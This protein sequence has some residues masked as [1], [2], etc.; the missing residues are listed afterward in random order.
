MRSLF[1]VLGFLL[2]QSACAI[3]QGQPAPA[4]E[5]KPLAGTAP[6]HLADY[7]GRVVLLDF[8]ASWCGPCRQSLPLFEKMRGEFG[9][10]GFEVVAVNV[11]EDPQDGLDFLKKYPVTYPT[12]RDPQGAIALQYDVKAMPSSYLIGRD[13]RVQVVKLG[14]YKNDM[15]KLRDAVTA[16]LGEE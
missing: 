7:K 3:E 6:V 2:S 12:L 16:L 14:F 15:P 5:G 4:F 1:F 11:D 9:A 8:W 10:R 13:G